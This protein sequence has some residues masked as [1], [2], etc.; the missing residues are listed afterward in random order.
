MLHNLLILTGTGSLLFEKVWF[1]LPALESKKNI[2]SALLT[3][4]QVYSRNAT[5]MP[6]SY[7]S[8][9]NISVSFVSDPR[10]ELRCCLFHDEEDGD[11]LGRT[12]A[13][14]ILSCFCEQFGESAPWTQPGGAST[15]LFAPFANRLP[16]A[17]ALSTRDVL[18]GLRQVRGVSNAMLVY[19]DGRTVTT[20]PVEELLGLVANLKAM[21]TFSSEI[22]A[23]RDER[24]DAVELELLENRVVVHRLR[25]S[26]SFIIVC[27]REEPST[28]YTPYIA[29][30]VN[31]L[32][33]VLKLAGSLQTLK[34]GQ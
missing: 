28:T 6:L 13:Q 17:I 2:I 32:N 29:K 34:I 5:G 24:M 23:S 27:S 21:L 14:H 12:V 1:S 7:L 8:F 18:M 25:Q 26:V 20:T 19:D 10:T 16:E 22:M 9:G 31:L 30:A 4:L 11:A 3:T 33:Q 15:S